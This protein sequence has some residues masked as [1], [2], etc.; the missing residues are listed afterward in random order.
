MRFS[1]LK[2]SEIEKE[3]DAIR[4]LGKY[5]RQHYVS[6]NQDLRDE[7]RQRQQEAKEQAFVDLILRAYKAEKVEGFQA[8]HGKKGNH[9]V[10]VGS[11]NIPVTRLFVEEIIV[12]SRKL[13]FT[14]VDVLGFEFEMG[15]FP[16]ILEEAKSKG[17]ELSPKYIPTEV[18]DKRA[19]E[20]DQVSFHDVAYIAVK[21][22]FQKTKVAVELA[23]YSIFFSQGNLDQVGVSIKNGGS[24][25]VVH[26]GSVIKVNKD[27]NGIISRDT[28]TKKWS[29]WIDYWAVDF[30]FESKREIIT[31]KDPITGEL[32]DKWTGDF[33]FE[34]EW[35]TFRTKK[36]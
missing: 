21:P 33:V 12:E 10:V 16:N 17:I 35:Q 24:K 14:K 29:D 30:D 31:V 11:V 15:L 8:F 26:R 4:K 19:V 1:T 23:N 32:E 22:H 25:V 34:N 5:E 9:M 3:I 20:N 28:L 36:D 13:R 27:K 6:V 7:E 18:F 2:K